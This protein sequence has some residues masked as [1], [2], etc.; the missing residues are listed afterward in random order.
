LQSID[1][2]DRHKYASSS[3]SLDTSTRK[4]Y[5]YY[6]DPTVPTIEELRQQAE[7]EKRKT[8]MEKI[9]GREEWAVNKEIAKV[10]EWETVV[11]QPVAPLLSSNNANKSNDGKTESTS[12]HDQKPEFQDDDHDEEGLHGFKIKEKELDIPVEEGIQNTGE[13]V[14]FKK[15]KLGDSAIKSRKKKPLRKKD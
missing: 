3:T 12:T 4:T 5:N 7:E 14:T 11:S 10:G 1:P 2:K 15:R 6:I 8:E 13:E 9:E